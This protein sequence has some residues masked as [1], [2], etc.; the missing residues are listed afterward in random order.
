MR[1]VTYEPRPV[2][3]LAAQYFT[4]AFKIHTG[5][6]GIISHDFIILRKKMIMAFFRGIGLARPSGWLE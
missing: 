3:R 5:T 4:L 6:L 2:M 1:Q